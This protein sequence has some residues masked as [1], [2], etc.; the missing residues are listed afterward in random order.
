MN[1]VPGFVIALLAVAAF[2]GVIY[3]V[4][5]LLL[6]PFLNAAPLHTLRTAKLYARAKLA[7]RKFPPADK[8]G[9]DVLDAYL[10]RNVLRVTPIPSVLTKL[11]HTAKAVYELE[12][13]SLTQRPLPNSLGDTIEAARYRDQLIAFLAKASD[14]S[15]LPN[16]TK[17][18]VAVFENFTAQLPDGALMSTEDMGR[19]IRIEPFTFYTSLIDIIARPGPAAMAVTLPF[20]P[21][22]APDLKL[23][24]TIKDVLNHNTQEASGITSDKSSK[25]LVL[26]HQAEGP[27]RKV[28]FDYLRNTPLLDL[29]NAD[30]P[31]D[32]PQRTRFEHHWI[33]AG[34]GHGKTQTLQS[35]IANDLELVAKDEATVVVIDSQGDLIRNIAN[36]KVFAEG[37]PLHGRLCL[38]DPT[39]VEYPVALNF[40]DVGL[41][42]I[43]QY[44]QL[45]R[46][47]LL[48]GAIELLE[49]TLGSLLQA[50][51]TAK[52][53][54]MF[55]Y[56][57]RAMFVIPNA[58]IHTFRELLEPEGY[59]KYRDHL[60]RLQGT[61]KAFFATEFNTKEFEQT[62]RQVVRRIW[63]ILE[64]QT[65][66]RM[67]SHP[68]N[69]LD[70]F[71]ELNSSKVILINT[72]K[73]LLK[74][75]GTEIFG[76]F[77]IAA[78][79]QAT[80]ERAIIA[81]ASRKPAFVYIDECQDYLDQNVSLIL[82][83]ARKFNV[84]MI[85]AHQYL[86][87][88]APK[89]Y[90]S[91]AANTSIKFAGGVSSQDARSF[92]KMLR[93]E[94]EFIEEQAKGHFA[95]SVRNH[96]DR[97][98]SLRIPFG[99]LEAKERMT[100]EEARAV[101]ASMREKYAVHWQ[102]VHPEEPL[103]LAREVPPL[104]PAEP[105]PP[106]SPPVPRRAQQPPP[107]PAQAPPEPRRAPP[108]VVV[109]PPSRERPQSLPAPKKG[110]IVIKPSD[111]W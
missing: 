60:D 9:E 37:Q 52:Q 66:E 79:A 11:R 18:L 109:T 50:E 94:P 29:F 83:Q 28:L 93:C 42:R 97:A 53:S 5:F 20:F 22:D 80:Q 90:D 102:Q 27:P 111:K 4:V 40:F 65:F 31:F 55:R 73:E 75:N 33:V 106:P 32:I 14:N 41:E 58:T 38:I 62:K 6:R 25:P 12:G 85:L 64:N 70:L 86:G 95:V 24:K 17:T 68:K 19:F 87:Q 67:F 72:A 36:L 21:T 89:L 78:I 7:A 77:F 44:S 39:D 56:L 84:G 88:L 96:T 104:Q 108:A 103:V 34:T 74:Q 16:L 8:F 61:A 100:T 91:F 13:F 46:E 99:I 35:F 1:Y 107:Q 51:M 71:A 43:N 81:G 26:A 63:G 110:D 49:F 47:R 10:D 30:I 3:L 15:A 45:H 2:L 48:N 101:R 92:S 105:A 69:K 23:F 82:E 76:R 59:E 57:L 98:V 54:T